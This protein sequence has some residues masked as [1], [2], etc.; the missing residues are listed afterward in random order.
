MK[1]GRGYL[2]LT[3]PL[4]FLVIFFYVPLVSIIKTG[5]WE[6]GFTLRYIASV[7]QNDYHRRV[8]LFTIAQ[9]LGSTL[10][11][12]ALG[13]PGAYLFAKYDFPG[14]RVIR[15]VLTVPFVM[16]SVMVALGYILLFGKSGIVTDLIGRDPGILYSWK[17]I[18]LAHAFYNFPIVIRM[19]SSL[20]QRVNPHYE[21]AALSLGARGFSLFWRVTLPLISPAIFASAMLTFVF[22]FLSFSIPLIIGGYRYAT[23]EVDIF[24]AIMTLLDFKTGSALAI[25]QILLSMAFMYAYL[26]S[27]DAYA[28]REEQRVFR[29]PI[30]FRRGDWLSLRGLATALY[31]LIVFIFIVSPLLAVIYDSLRFN[32]HWSLEWYRRIFSTEYNPMFGLTTLD[33]IRNSLLFG[34]ATVVLSI[35][36]ALPIAYALHRWDF[37]GKRLFDILAMLPL[38]SSPI[39]LGL[40]YIKTFH[41]TPLYYTAWIIVAAHT[42]IAYP[43]VLR[44][45]STG[46]KKIKPNIFEAALSL[47]AREWKAFLR[48]ELPLVL[49]SLVVG[50]IFA[51]AMSI[52][53]LGAT[54]M[55][56]KPEYTTMSVAIYK[57][58][59]ARQFGSAS[60]LSVL[61]MAVSTAGFLIIERIGEEVW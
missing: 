34:L 10:L 56:A 54:Y 32:G 27:L 1:L 35:T 44:A 29:K 3:V 26:R 38:A 19:V 5:L 9:A 36:V 52:A 13:L 60:A 21:E 53:E 51:F 18:L 6:D 43:F 40:G 23:I 28:R 58:L 20:W 45:V 4:A 41:G 14:K 16:P 11:T 33:A 46:L 8:I 49:G 12:V 37:R 48:V 24:T 50:A 17:G 57:F 59:G 47:G 7:I 39:T 55:L 15:A 30:P 61:L 42:V 22:S 31:S 2:I 25:I